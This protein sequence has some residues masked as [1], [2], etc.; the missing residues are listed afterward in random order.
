M[1]KKLYAGNGNPPP[2]QKPT[3][4]DSPVDVASDAGNGEPPKPDVE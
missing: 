4:Q 1:S 2:P 3:K